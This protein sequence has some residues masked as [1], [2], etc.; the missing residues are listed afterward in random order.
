MK[1]SPMTMLDRRRFLVCALAA[2]AS[3]AP[4]GA[5]AGGGLADA[6]HYTLRGQLALQSDPDVRSPTLTTLDANEAVV[7]RDRVGRFARVRVGADFEGYVPATAIS[8]VWLKAHKQERELLLMRG[9]QPVRRYRM[10]LG[11]EAPA[12]DQGDKQRRG[13]RATPEGRFF[14]AEL[15]AS[16]GAARYGARS[17]RLS[18]PG[19]EDA[20]RGLRDG[21]IDY[22]TYLRIVRAVRAGEV[23]PQDTPLGGSIRIHGGGGGRDW[24][25]GCLALDDRAVVDLF[26]RVRRGTRV[27]VYRSAAQASEMA[28]PRFVARQV[29]AGARHQLRAPALYTR[30][31]MSVVPLRFPSGDLDPRQA[32]CA[33]IVVRAARQAGLDLQALVHEDRLL[34][35]DLYRAGERPSH[36]ID[37]RRVRNLERFLARHALRPTLAPARAAAHAFQPGDLVL[38]ETGIANGTPFDHIGVVDEARD[39]DGFPTVINIWTV[40]AQTA[41]IRLLGERYPTVTA[42]FRL[43]HPL[44][45]D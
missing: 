26:A 36:Q 3:P 13:D 25:L 44:D 19:A 29:L 7:L 39:A 24:T 23:P 35:P 45:F 11:A 37:H 22:P 12:G 4:G 40:G 5:Q 14:L 6:R 10:A 43:R 27:E 42:H 38:F 20:R 31:A 15:D 9:E 8:D 33:D 18:Y 21:L 2:G 28:H 41:S 32:V 17:L 30:Q 1:E 16:P 34:R